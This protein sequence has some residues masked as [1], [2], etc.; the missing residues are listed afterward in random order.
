MA[1]IGTTGKEH[2]QW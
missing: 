1:A 2:G